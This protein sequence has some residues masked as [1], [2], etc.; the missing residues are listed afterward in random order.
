[1]VNSSSLSGFLRYLAANGQR[2][3]GRLPPLSKISSE[4]GVSVASLREQLEVARSLGLIDVKP[5]TGIRVLPY[6][7]RPSVSRSLYYAI[8]VNSEYFYSY[9]NLRKHIETSYWYEATA[10]LQ[11]E[12]LQKLL[13][14]IQKAKE[15]LDQQ[16]IQIPH[17]EHRDLHL[18]IY[19][20]LSNPFVLGILEAYWEVYEAI[21]LSIYTDYEYL[22]EV[23]C[24]HEKM[25]NAVNE[26]DYSGGYRYLRDHMDLLNK[27]SGSKTI[28]YFE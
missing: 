24:Y 13:L 11:Q 12:D 28:Q 3:G 1:M 7:F 9:S 5:K 21:G 8:E 18:T 19:N 20:Q 17:Q 26:G 23:W 10:L 4:L 14:L 2:L 6:S 15:K 16:P 22:K 27:R 25:V